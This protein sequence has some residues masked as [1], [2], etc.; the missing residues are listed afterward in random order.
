[1]RW[2]FWWLAT[3]QV[4]LG[5]SFSVALSMEMTPEAR[6]RKLSLNL[7]GALPTQEEYASVA[8]INDKANLE[9]FF[10]SKVFEYTKTDEFLYKFSDRILEDL[11]INIAPEGGSSRRN[12]LYVYQ[13]FNGSNFAPI[14]ALLKEG[15]TWDEILSSYE[16]GLLE[17]AVDAAAQIEKQQL[18]NKINSTVSRYNINRLK[19]VRILMGLDREILESCG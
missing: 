2:L 12:Q 8:K 18:I 7:K 6:L 19:A 15:K 9:K 14:F 13:T 10:S 5:F 1:M 16:F 11:R 3:C 4:A 17:L